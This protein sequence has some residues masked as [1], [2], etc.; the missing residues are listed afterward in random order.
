MMNLMKNTIKM[1]LPN[2]AIEERPLKIKKLPLLYRELYSF[3]GVNIH[4][5]PFLVIK[6]KDK[7]LG[8]RDFKK[9]SKVIHQSDDSPQI[10]YLKEL[11]FNKVQRMIENEFN[12]VVEK[13]QI[14]L[15]SLNISIRPEISRVK[16]VSKLS[17][18]SVNILIREILQGDLSGKKK[19]EIA[20]IFNTT[21]MTVGRAIEPLIVNEL[22]EE[23]KIGVSKYMQFVPRAELW[24]FLRDNI[25]SPIEEVIYIDK[26]PKA[27]PYSGISALSKLSMLSEDS[28]STFASDKKA[29]KK[30]FTNT[31]PVLEEFGKS[32][33]ELWNRPTI[34][35]KNGCINVIDI[36]LISKKDSDE[37]VQ[38]ELEELLENNELDIG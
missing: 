36:F 12:F 23:E 25:K 4:G 28:I 24:K 33:V 14:H 20:D 31:K 6:V 16:S 21:K 37:R 11:H 32:R 27:L 30:R 7:S 18:L 19:V 5:R 13:K 3:D 8:P 9:H 22:C 10:W 38:I 34:L 35:V 26:V 17:G 15:P 29:F 2:L 1:Y